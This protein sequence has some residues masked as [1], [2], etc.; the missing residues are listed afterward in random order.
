MT[1]HLPCLSSIEDFIKVPC[2]LF[3]LIV[4]ETKTVEVNKPDKNSGSRPSTN[5]LQKNLDRIRLV[6]YILN[7]CRG[8]SNELCEK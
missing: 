5:F 8:D 6:C 7:N 1:C 3:P 2:A 4:S